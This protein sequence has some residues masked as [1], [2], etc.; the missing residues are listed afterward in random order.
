MPVK[1]RIS[2]AKSR[3]GC[4]NC[5]KRHVKCDEQGPPC[6][7]CIARESSTTCHFPS[8]RPA[9]FSRTTAIIQRPSHS[10]SSSSNPSPTPPSHPSAPS[11]A[12]VPTL[13]L[14]LDTPLP[15]TPTTRLLEL[16]LLHRWTTTTYR[17]FTSLPEDIPNMTLTFPRLGLRYPFLLHGLFALAAL[18]SSLT[19]APADSARYLRAGMAYYDAASRSFRGY[20]PSLDGAGGDLQ[21]S[22][23]M[24]SALAM[25]LYVGVPLCSRA[26]GV[27]GGEA[28][29]GDEDV[30]E[31]VA[32]IFNLQVGMVELAACNARGLWSSEYGPALVRAEEIVKTPLPGGL[33]EDTE[34]ALAR[35]K[36]VVEA[37]SGEEEGMYMQAWGG[38]KF[39]FTEEKRDLVRSLCIAWPTLAGKPFM[40]AFRNG[41]EV[42]LWM[43]MHWGVLVHRMG[44][45][46]WW[47][48]GLGKRLVTELSEKMMLSTIP[49]ADMSEWWEGIAWARRHVG[50]DGMPSEP[51]ISLAELTLAPSMLNLT[52]EEELP[53]EWGYTRD[54]LLNGSLLAP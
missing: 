31:M 25:A 32:Q 30:L 43:L 36:R 19:C 38:L 1:K 45:R 12:L 44:R 27:V 23:Y 29:Y 20:L 50:L 9:T 40:Q 11:S 13:P 24:F 21:Y 14:H 39:C 10:S 8:R 22:L 41:D 51:I 46:A 28:G 6:A 2:H 3:S 26:V 5:K 49:E 18:E 33:G 52:S 17:S 47:A 4:S 16:E 15:L 7:N 35:M 37:A 42:A 53:P 48:M 34:E 54:S